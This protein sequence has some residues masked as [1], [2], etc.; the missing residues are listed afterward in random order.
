MRQQNVQHPKDLK[1]RRAR[2]STGW[3]LMAPFA[4][5]PNDTVIDKRR[6]NG[7]LANDF[8]MLLANRSL[9]TVVMVGCTTDGGVEATVRDGYNRGYFMVVVRDCVGTYT[10]Q[11]HEGA[12][13]RMERSAD[14][15]DSTELL[16]L[17]GAQS[18]KGQ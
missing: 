15:I 14:V 3:E 13:K 9:K 1:P 8:E 4:P 10:Q 7:F 2:G 5:T 18:Q 17:W 12:L 16:R 11:G 6:P